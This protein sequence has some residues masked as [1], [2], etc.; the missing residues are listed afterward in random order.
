MHDV[1]K[2]KN[3]QKIE[4][5]HDSADAFLAVY[6][7]LS[8]PL[9]VRI[10]HM[11]VRVSGQD[12]PCTKLDETLPVG[13]STISYHIGILRRAG[14]ISVRKEGR[15]YFYQVRESTLNTYAPEFL[16]YLRG[17]DS[18]DLAA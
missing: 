9:R 5:L 13:K 8:E 16:A 6:S 4:P 17:T 18:L 10:L 2:K 7:A 14:L 3:S 1:T 15:N 11:M 12:F